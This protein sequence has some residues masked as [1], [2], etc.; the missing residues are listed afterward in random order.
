[1]GAVDSW[2][3]RRN[4]N[5][6]QELEVD[7]QEPYAYQTVATPM[8]GH[9]QNARNGNSFALIN[10]EVRM[11]ILQMLS[12]NGTLSEFGRS[13]QLAFFGDLGTAWNGPHPYHPDNHFN[14]QSIHDGPI[15]IKLIN[16][17]E[18]ILGGFGF[19]ARAKIAGYFLKLDLAWGV[20]N[21]VI[22]S[23]L[24]YLS[25]ALDI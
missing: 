6:N 3:L 10:S 23:P 17:R 2:I 14:T 11:P 4:P 13:F 12:K 24:L 19:G 21:G 15:T 1:M 7:P 5:F 16:Q 9:I 25:L 22:N 8:R 20:E 18:P